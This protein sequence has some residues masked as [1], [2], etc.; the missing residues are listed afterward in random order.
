MDELRQRSSDGE[1]LEALLAECFAIVRE[2]GKRQMGMR[3]FD[4]QLIGGMAL[5]EGQISEMK[6]GEGK[7]LTATLAVVLNSLAV[8]DGEPPS[9]APSANAGRARGD[10]QRL[11]GA[12]RRGMD[13]PDLRGAGR[14]R[15]SA[16]EPAVLRGQAAGVL[17]RRGVRHQLGVRLR[18]PARQH[19]QGSS[20]KGPARPLLR[21]RGRG[22]QHPDR[23][24]AHAADHLRCAR[25]GGRPVR[26]VRAPGAADEARADPGGHGPA[27]Q[28]GL[29]GRLRLR[30]R[31]EAEDGGDHRAGGGQGGA[32][33]GHRPPVPGG[34]R[35]PGQPPDPVAAR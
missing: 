16:A 29:P 20:R 18:L 11:P 27:H 19:G 32:L 8:R 4:V 1:Q 35:P 30:D 6:T 13:E 33:P 3:H 2:T 25:T 10:G 28:E 14:E 31:R 26:Q 7:T 22:R 23:R 15:G 9:R 24:G 21:G 5:H 12:T 17:V 34:E